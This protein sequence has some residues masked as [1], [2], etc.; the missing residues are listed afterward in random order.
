MNVFVLSGSSAAFDFNEQFFELAKSSDWEWVIQS[1]ALEHGRIAG[2]VRTE[3]YID[4]DTVAKCCDV[5]ISHCGAGT[6]FWA[7]EQ[8]L[9]FIAIVDTTRPDDHQWDL[10]DYLE[11]ENF[12]MVLRGRI[13]SLGEIEDVGELC[14]SE[15]LQEGLVNLE[16]RLSDYKVFQSDEQAA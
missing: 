7:L 6:A 16:E 3:T 13:P 14:Y 9:N 15:Y 10:G 2:N 12:C 1:V 11:R 5:L 4:Q 8:K